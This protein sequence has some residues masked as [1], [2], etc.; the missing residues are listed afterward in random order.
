MGRL[1]LAEASDGPALASIYG[2]YVTNTPATF[3]LEPPSAG[4][5]ADRVRRVSESYPWLVYEDDDGLVRGFAYAYRHAEREAYAWSVNTAVYISSGFLRMGIG[6]ALYSALI[7]LVR[8]QGFYNAYAGITLPNLASTSLHE[9]LGFR[10]FATFERV[11]FK[12]GVWHSVSYWHLLL[13]EPG[14][15]PAIPLEPSALRGSPEWQ[16]VTQLRS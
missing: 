8:L 3:E 12:L 9:A 1:R 16:A 2:F 13:R 7:P 6:R 11:G 10:H 15:S 14:E 5:M 4:Q